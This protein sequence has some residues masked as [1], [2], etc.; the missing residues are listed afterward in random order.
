MSHITVT[1]NGLL[2]SHTYVYGDDPPAELKYAPNAIPAEC[3]VPGYMLVDPSSDWPNAITYRL[4]AL[5]GDVAT[6][7]EESP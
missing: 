5:S 7:N 3:V 1:H 6:Y 2:A 4:G